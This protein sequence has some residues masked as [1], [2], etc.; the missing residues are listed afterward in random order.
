VP[1]RDIARRSDDDWGPWH[2][3]RLSGDRWRGPDLPQLHPVFRQIEPP[4]RPFRVG[5]SY[6]VFRSLGRDDASGYCG[7]S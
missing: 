7:V 3:P 5:V 4:L 2:L 6:R 1:N